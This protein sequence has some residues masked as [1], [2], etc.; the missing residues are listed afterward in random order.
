MSA[1]GTEV[2]DDGCMGHEE[3]KELEKC[4]ETRL[5]DRKVRGVNHE[6]SVT[7]LN[8]PTYKKWTLRE[9]K[10]SKKLKDWKG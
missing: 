8:G 1:V 5:R 10:N 3:R 2:L 7:I 4:I 9:M 6:G